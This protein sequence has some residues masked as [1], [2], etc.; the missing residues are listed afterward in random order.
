MRASPLLVAIVLASCGGN[1]DSGVDADVTDGPP[2]GTPLLDRLARAD[3]VVEDGARAGDSSWRIWG[4]GSL[5]V[6]PVFTVPTADCG[7]LV[8]YT[9]GAASPTARV[10]RLDA[11]DAIV[12]SHDLGPYTLRG[13]AAEDDGAFAALLWDE[14]VTPAALHVQRFSAS[15]AP[16]WSTAL[17]DALAAPTDFGIG[18]SRLTYGDGRYGAYYHVHGISGFAEGHEG[19]QL[20]WLD[21]GTGAMTNGWSWGC[22]HS[23]SAL[24]GYHPVDDRFV[25]MCVTDCFPG[26]SGD[27]AA[28]SIGGLYLDNRTRVHGIDAGCNGSVAGE[29]GSAAAAPTGWKVVWNSH[30][31]PAT[32]GQS[33]YDRATMNQDVGFA[34]ITGDLTPGAVTWLT[35]TAVDEQNPSIARWQPDGETAEQYLVGWAE[36]GTPRH[37]LAV[38]D[39]AGAITT[40]PVDVS[41]TA[42]WGQ[43]DDP[44][45]VHRNGDVA[46]SWF[47]GAGETA[48]HLA[49]IRSGRACTP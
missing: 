25:A 17:V 21:A 1:S 16:G 10:V 34:P 35:T 28:S 26:T 15:G 44:F 3:V 43:R 8:G 48:L 2:V 41:A 13:L 37:L 4:T 42:R 40:A 30:Q 32:P 33:S 46:W 31:A 24:L 5:E 27:F 20:K 7:T 23:M 49:R 47:D 19:D 45:R 22:S 6:A 11:T 36:V 29:L 12:S 39:S 14:S 18:D 9:T 38:I